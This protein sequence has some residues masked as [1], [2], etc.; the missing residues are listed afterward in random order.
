MPHS[1]KCN[2]IKHLYIFPTSADDN[3][4]K[5]QTYGFATPK[6]ALDSNQAE[7][8]NMTLDV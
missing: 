3:Y 4:V 5:Y 2:I 6:T 7:V 1:I 8:F